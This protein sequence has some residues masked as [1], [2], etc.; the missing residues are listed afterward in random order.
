MPRD[1]ASVLAAFRASLPPALPQSVFRIDGLDRIGLPVVQANVL[2]PGEP[3]ASGHGYGATEAE[4]EV[5][6]WG[7]LCEEVHVHAWARRAPYRTASH[8]ALVAAEG[9]DR[10]LDPLTL[11][12]PAGSP[13]APDMPLDWV[14]G[15]RLDG[16]AAWL[17]REWVV[18]YPYQMGASPAH[19]IVPITNGLGA[20]L[21]REHAIAHGLME[22]LQ[23]DGNVLTY[24][25]LDQGVV[26]DLDG[27]PADV[28]AL[29]DRLRAHGIAP[30]VKLAC[31]DFGL[32]NVYVVGDDHG[33]PTVPVQVTACGEASHPDRDRAV[34][35]ALLEFVGSRARKAATHGPIDLL[36]RALPADFVA[37][38]LAQ[39]VASGGEAEEG[40]AVVAMAEWVGL[41]AQT[42]RARLADTVF[43]ERA[44]VPFA[45][46]PT[47][48]PEAVE[49][50]AARLSVLL[51]RLAGEGLHAVWVD[52][53][54]PGSEVV[55]AKVIVPGLECET[56]SY[57]RIGW[58]GVRRLR[59]RHDPLVRDRPDPGTARVRLRPEDEARA[60]GPAWF[61]AARAERIVGALYPLYR[62]PNLFAAQRLAATRRAGA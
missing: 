41:D 24:R 19:L 59:A 27:A 4:A 31:T 61:D 9:A 17:P 56:M 57:H 6:A 25:A 21:D 58:R 5:G 34:R 16:A 3:A 30:V 11:C 51:E 23:R 7:E 32:A 18:A 50:S 36:R 55:V 12:L 47:V 53:S 52:C 60:G 1:L 42:L 40:R 48:R 15:Q 28:R 49:A 20:G 44:R 26:V 46:L 14:L 33:A 35:K 45:A 62:E 38:E 43:A 13:Y 8:A 29:R 2:L 22:L 39:E 10:V 54:P 37:H